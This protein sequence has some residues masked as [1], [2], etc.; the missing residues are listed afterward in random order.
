MGDAPLTAE[1]LGHRAW[2]PSGGCTN[3]ID[4]CRQEAY[5]Q[6]HGL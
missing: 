1:V 3:I 4:Q 6:L 2:P 5:E